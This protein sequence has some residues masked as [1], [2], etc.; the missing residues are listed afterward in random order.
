MLNS[1]RNKLLLAFVLML[2]GALAATIAVVWPSTNQSII[3]NARQELE[4]SLR[5]FEKLLAENGKLRQEQVVFLT[6]EYGFKR[7]LA[8]D[9][10]DTVI[11]VLANHGE[12]ISADMIVLLDTAGDLVVSTHPDILDRLNT[13]DI[14]NSQLQPKSVLTVADQKPYQLFVAPVLAPELI[15]WVG[16]GFTIDQD[17]LD[18]FKQITTTELTLDYR[19]KDQT[20]KLSTSDA[21]LDPNDSV[22][23]VTKLLEQE[24][25][26]ITV[27]LSTSISEKLEPFL[28]LR[29]RMIVIGLTTL[30]FATIL[31]LFISRGISRPISVLSRAAIR[32]ARG[33]Y[34]ETIEVKERN[35]FG[36]LGQALN[37]MRQAIDDR[38]KHI[39]YQANHDLLTAIPNRYFLGDWIKDLLREEHDQLNFG[40]AIVHVYNFNQLNDLY[41]SEICDQLIKRVA[42]TIQVTL[43]KHD[44]IGRLDGNQFLVFYGDCQNHDI[45]DHC[46]EILHIL[47]QTFK[48]GPI[49]VQAE[50]RIGAAVYPDHGQRYDE[51]MRRA[52]I[53]LSMS[54]RQKDSFSLYQ[55]GQD[56]A[57]LRKINITNRL[58][59]AIKTGNFRLLYQP[60]LDVKED[61][62][63]Q[64]EALVR[65]NDP[66]LGEVYPDEFI[67]L[68]ER[69]GDI[70][71]IT[72]WVFQRAMEQVVQWRSMN[73]DIGISVNLSARD[74]KNDDF[75]DEIIDNIKENQLSKTDFIFEVTESAVM[76]DPETAITNLKKLQAFGLQV[77][78][79]DFGTGF[80]S[81]SQLKTLPISELKID[82]S[83]ILNIASDKDD[84]KIVETTIDMAHHLK[85]KVIAEGVEDLASLNILRDMGCDII[86]GYHL[87]KPIPAEEFQQWLQQSPSAPALSA[88][89]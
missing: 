6:N 19:D 87:S 66:S 10:E 80:S 34:S 13:A 76:E 50:V 62:I 17:L 67:P 63:H 9:E 2:G 7:A 74:V 86:Q 47:Q 8:T 71:G 39:S 46:H 48:I 5:V 12:R 4:V 53:A 30:F 27:V 26:A 20:F 42:Q 51:L 65:W 33:D 41:G 69:S 58:Q 83:F 38:E 32:I 16:L 43:G 57:H 68:A 37:N 29:Q 82:K 45:S 78:M 84:Q 72:R 25:A 1:F 15:A 81:L 49:S 28:P 24:S 88:E 22:T 59:D 77:A 23:T 35:E 40:L 52:G 89:L 3:E 85:L 14:I 60:Q 11:S 64:V 73:I 21:S 31:A 61:K 54:H 18:T 79:D 55:R 75:I 44:K 70:S 56:E 36:Q